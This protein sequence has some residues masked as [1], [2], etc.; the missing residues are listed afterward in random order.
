MAETTKTLKNLP[1]WNGDR[2]GFQLWWTRFKAYASKEGWAKALKPEF[3][4]EL[5]DKEEGAFDSDPDVAK[6]Q[7]N[8]VKL[9]AEAVWAIS[10]AL[11]TNSIMT[12]YYATI[13]EEYPEGVA[14]KTVQS[15]LLEY[16][17]KDDLAAVE[18]RERLA[19]VSM[20]DNEDPKVLIEKLDEIRNMYSHANF[21][22]QEVDLVAVAMQ[23]A[24]DVYKAA[25][26]QEQ[27]IR[28]RVDNKP[29]VFSDVY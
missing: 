22:V 28:R 3:E 17:P 13:S 5:P 18:Y 23:K 19:K 20:K 9:N 16:Q 26:A 25:L 7:K 29:L 4:K 15:I 8:A 12:K 11:T 6:L 2:E 27:R 1:T 21:V 14:W 24:P 10:M